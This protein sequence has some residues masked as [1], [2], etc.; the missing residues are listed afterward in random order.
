MRSKQHILKRE[1]QLFKTKR[2]ILGKIEVEGLYQHN[3]ENEDWSGFDFS[4]IE[5]SGAEFRNCNLSGCDF[6]ETNLCGAVFANCNLTG[7]R[8]YDTYLGGS[9]IFGCDFTGSNINQAFFYIE[10]NQDEFFP[11]FCMENQGVKRG[12]YHT[13]K[14]GDADEGYQTLVVTEDFQVH[15]IHHCDDCEYCDAK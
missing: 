14:I 6:S 2:D 8:F 12:E 5:L 7:A 1:I 3:F 15:S 9:E 13:F 10:D 4:D 11:K